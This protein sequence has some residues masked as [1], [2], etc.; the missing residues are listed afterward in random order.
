MEQKINRRNRPA[1]IFYY[2]GH[3]DGKIV[4]SWVGADGKETQPYMTYHEALAT[5]KANNCKAKFI[6]TRVDL[7]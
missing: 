3:R 7:P 4:Y 5:A 6:R 1:M 2:R